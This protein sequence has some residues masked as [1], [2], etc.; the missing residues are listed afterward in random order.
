MDD[1]KVSAITVS[2][3]IWSSGFNDASWL[4]PKIERKKK[5]AIFGF[6][7]K[8]ENFSR[9]AGENKEDDI[10]RTSRAAPLYIMERL[11]VETDTEPANYV[12][13]V[14]NKGPVISPV[15]S[16]GK[17]LTKT[18]ENKYDY[19]LTGAIERNRLNLT[20]TVKIFLYEQKSGGENIIAEYK[21][22]KSVEE[23]AFNAAALAIDK[24]IEI[25]S[26]GKSADSADYYARPKPAVAPY[27]LSG[28]GQLLTQTLV[29]NQLVSNDIWGEDNMLNWYMRLSDDDSNNNCAKLMY[30]KGIIASIDYG[31]KAYNAHIANLKEYVDI[32][33]D[34]NPDDLA[35]KLSP[36][37]YKKTNDM[38]SFGEICGILKNKG[39][40][41]YVDWLNRVSLEQPKQLSSAGDSGENAGLDILYALMKEA[42]KNPARAPLFYKKLLNSRIFF[43]T[44][45]EPPEKEKK[46]ISEGERLPIRGFS[47]GTLP[48][49]SSKNRMLDN[50]SPLKSSPAAYLAMNGKDF[51]NTCKGAK[52]VLNPWS[53]VAKELLPA[54]IDSILTGKK[55]QDPVEIKLTKETKVLVGEPANIPSGFIESLRS[56]CKT[57]RDIKMVYVLF[58]VM[59]ERREQAITIFVKAE[60]DMRKVFNEI[61]NSV[62]QYIKELGYIDMMPC[63]GHYNMLAKYKPVYMN[64]KN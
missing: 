21:S 63:E 64:L 3:P 58:V 8:E 6:S 10:G 60:G 55:Q 4:F 13:L 5:I 47:D 22:D 37:F 46:I 53:D 7:V 59:P 30:L 24:L 31:G 36:L 2:Q 52:F 20:T 41:E 15:R 39:S 61:K 28:L 9:Q 11:F 48:I 32:F 16:E 45:G 29:Q 12:L 40:I 18:L 43:L 42:Y 1:I 26:C 19:I 34:I 51:F 49:F 56:Y 27:Y 33:K 44:A 17:E 54:E 35:V 23:T 38:N 57:N 62:S 50:N 25:L 14:V